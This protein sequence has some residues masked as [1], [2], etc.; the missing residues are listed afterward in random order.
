MNDSGKQAIKNAKQT[1]QLR[2]DA[3]V[4]GKRGSIGKR[5]SSSGLSSSTSSIGG[6]SASTTRSSSSISGINSRNATRRVQNQQN[7]NK[8]IKVAEKIPVA[9]KYAKMA[10]KIQKIKNS[11]ASGF[12]SSMMS[13]VNNKSDA[14]ADDVEEANRAEQA[15]EEYKPDA[16]EGRYTAITAR[17]MKILV[18]LVLA[19]IVVGAIFFCVIL[20]SSLT[21]SGGKAYLASKSNPT[22]EELGEWYGNQGDDIDNSTSSASSD[23]STSTGT[24]ANN[25]SSVTTSFTDLLSKGGINVNRLDEVNARQLVIVDSSGT[26]ASV[27]FYEKNGSEWTKDDSLST[28]G[29]VGSEGTTDEPS[30]TKSATPKGL[31]SIGD[32][33][34]QDSKPNTKLST[35]KITSNTY[36]VDDPNSKF[37]NKRVEG[38]SNKDWNSAE[39]MSEISVYKYGF[40]INYN[41]N[42]VKKGTGSAMFF[43]ISSNRP[44][45]GCVSVPEDMVIKYL[46]KL[47]KSNNPYI[48]II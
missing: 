35:F 25:N 31:Y 41:V 26:S 39:H 14:S 23:S 29:Y 12:F 24:S 33:F 43:H 21:D 16:A 32:A 27:S 8:A 2:K 38:T 48:L 45:G 47:D 20:V 1:G 37:Y 42:P 9:R 46:E 7:I 15:G 6:G 28:S 36:W 3:A 4:H 5:D 13:K 11:R 22:E 17:Q 30:E 44:T 19:G 18:V 40:V 10:E 34:Y